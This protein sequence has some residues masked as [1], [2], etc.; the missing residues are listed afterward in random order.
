MIEQAYSSAL[1][2]ITS[3]RSSANQNFEKSDANIAALSAGHVNEIQTKDR[4]AVNRIGSDLQNNYAQTFDNA[5]GTLEADR[6]AQLNERGAMLQ[7]LGIQEAGLGEAGKAQS[8]AIARLTE[9]EAGAMKQAQGYQ[10]ADLVRNTEQAQSQASAG[11]ERRGELHKQLQGILGNLDQAETELG[12]NKA[13][14]KIQA[15]QSGRND[16]NQRMSGISDSIAQIDDQVQ[17][18][19]ESDRDYALKLQEMANKASGAGS[20]GV[21]SAVNES[22]KNRG[23][24]PSGYAQAYADVASTSSFNPQVNG[25]KKLWMIQQMKKKNPKL[26]A[27]EIQAYVFGVENYGTDKLGN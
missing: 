7:R 13:H 10:A 18:K 16:Y 9:N 15:Y 21:F 19:T 3:A 23:V 1:G 5:Q 14:E 12:Q 25:D 27:R 17:H 6:T 20:G 24:D 2:N 22:L 26:D 8:D 11:L 4:D